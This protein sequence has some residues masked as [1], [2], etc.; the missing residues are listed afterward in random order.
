MYNK[1]KLCKKSTFASAFEKE[2][3]KPYWQFIT[4]IGSS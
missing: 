4:K 2:I 1:I 3:Q